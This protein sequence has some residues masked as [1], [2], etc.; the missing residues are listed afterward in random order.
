MMNTAFWHGKRV[1]VTGHTGFKGGWLVLWLRQL[2]AT[3]CG[4]ALPPATTPNLFELARVAEGMVA[5][6]VDDVKQGV[7]AYKIA[8][9][10]ADIAKHHPHAIDRDNAMSKARFEFRWLDQFNLSY[11]PDTAIAFHDDTLP[12][13]PAKMAH[14]CS[15]CGP[16]FCSMAISQNIRKKF[17][18]AEAQEKLVADAQTIAAGMQ[19]MSERF[20]EQGGHLYQ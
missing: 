17:G 16:K 4:I 3:V 12:A 18:N 6:I 1:L 13:E 15:M 8:C 9:H 14:F 20:R 19:E 5:V 11:D 7:I 10:A 2:G